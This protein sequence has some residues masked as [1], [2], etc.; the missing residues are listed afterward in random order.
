M[1]D[2]NPKKHLEIETYTWMG[3]GV[4]VEIDYTGNKVSLLEQPQRNAH[5]K[6]VFAGRS[7]EYAQGW[8]NIMDAMKFAAAKAMEKLEKHNEREAK[9]LEKKKREFVDLLKD[10]G[11]K[12][13]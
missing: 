13:A 3:V 12:R 8:Q 7:P 9:A 1:N 2:K 6:W 10:E 5:K 11:K 4:I